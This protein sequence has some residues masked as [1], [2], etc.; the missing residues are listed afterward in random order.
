MSRHQSTAIKSI[1]L[2]QCCV[3]DANTGQI[4]PIKIRQINHEKDEFATR[5]RTA[6]VREKSDRSGNTASHLAATWK[7]LP[8]QRRG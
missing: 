4:S 3:P 6:W 5:I 1:F 7:R 8:F 2:G